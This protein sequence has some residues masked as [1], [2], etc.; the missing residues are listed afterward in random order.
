MCPPL[1]NK[2]SGVLVRLPSYREKYSHECFS[3]QASG[4]PIRR[5][6]RQA[7][8]HRCFRS[9]ARE[10]EPERPSASGPTPGK[11]PNL[12]KKPTSGS[13]RELHAGLHVFFQSFPLRWMGARY[14]SSRCHQEA[15]IRLR[16]QPP[17]GYLGKYLHIDT[18]RRNIHTRF[19]APALPSFICPLLLMQTNK[20]AVTINTKSN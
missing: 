4:G 17:E 8:S 3:M 18:G 11:V 2:R 10:R 12:K 6:Y 15:D 20:T 1:G 7:V 5:S 14:M 19:K 9:V 13:P 16:L